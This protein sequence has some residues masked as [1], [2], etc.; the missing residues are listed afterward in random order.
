MLQRV[1]WCNACFGMLDKDRVVVGR[2]AE[3]AIGVGEELGAAVCRSAWLAGV[4]ALTV[5]IAGAAPASALAVEPASQVGGWVTDEPAQ[6]IATGGGRTYLGGGFSYIGP[7][8]GQGVVV[9]AATG[10]LVDG[11]AQLTG[12][13]ATKAI[14]D[15]TGGLYVAGYFTAA[16]DVQRPGLLHLLSDGTVDPSFAPDVN[17]SVTAIALAGTTLYLAGGFTALGGQS[18]PGLGAIDLA[19]GQVTSW[20]PP[21]CFST[22]YDYVHDIEV[23]AGIV[24]VAGEKSCNYRHTLLAFDAITG[25]VRDFIPAPDG[26]VLDV[27][28]TATTVY[29]AGSFHRIG[30]ADRAGLAAL[31]PSWGQATEWDP[32]PNSDVSAL[33]LTGD[34]LY[35]GGTFNTIGGSSRSGVARLST[36]TGQADA[37]APNAKFVRDIDVSGSTVYIGGTFGAVAGQ[38]R[39]LVAAVSATTG[40]PTAWAPMPSSEVTVV[41]AFGANVFIS[42]QFASVGGVQREGVAAIDDATDS[43]LPWDPHLTA[44]ASAPEAGGRVTVSDMLLD[45]QT[46]Y[47]A[48]EFSTADGASH[49]NLVAVDATDGHPRAWNPAPN[50]P[51]RALRRD[52]ATLYVGGAFTTVG[53]QPR[54][55]L[56]AIDTASGAPTPWNPGADAAVEALALAGD[57][58]YAAGAFQ[59]AGGAGRPG[60]AALSLATGAATAWNPKPVGGI[61]DLEVIGGAVYAAGTFTAIAGDGPPQLAKLDPATGAAMEWDAGIVGSVNDVTALGPSVLVVGDFTLAGG[62]PRNNVAAFDADDATVLP[63]APEADIGGRA[64]TV[65]DSELIVAGRFGDPNRFPYVYGFARIP[66]ARPPGTPKASVSMTRGDFTVTWSPSPDAD[67]YV[68]EQRD[69]AGGWAPVPGDPATPGRSFSGDEASEGELRFRVTAVSTDGRQS[70]PSATSAPVIVDRT[71]PAA[72]SIDTDRDAD[73]ESGWF[74]GPVHVSVKAEDAV[75]PDGSAGAGLDPAS[76]PAEQVF[77]TTGVHTLSATVRDRVGNTSPAATSVVRLDL[78]PPKIAIACPASV[79][80]GGTEA[81][82]WSASDVGSGLNGPAEGSILS[83]PL[84]QGAFTVTAPE[85]EDVAGLAAVPA[86]CTYTAIAIAPATGVGR[87]PERPPFTVA[88]AFRLPSQARCLKPGAQ[89]TL[90]Y[91]RPATVTVERVEVRVGRRRVLLRRGAKARKSITL[92]K[93][94]SKKFTLTVKVTIQDGTVATAKRTYSICGRSRR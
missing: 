17:G 57:T 10:A 45:G 23:A 43:V 46:L 2:R 77:A 60:A 32:R 61:L 6:V 64:V 22:P 49:P 76:L 62:E 15:G 40:T 38:S 90:T 16:D 65:S 59:A 27:E 73:S 78:D 53:G 84:Q 80:V 39:R 93:L 44:E 42:G 58:I 20:N 88:A 81:A 36:T 94:P 72:P 21:G 41:A 25:A 68:L 79:P 91:R 87:P 82:R 75:A 19:T 66:L 50:G 1:P 35:V 28:A 70:V 52:R 4:L 8:T 13:A 83:T 86:R 47:L 5:L 3:W 9:G 24:Y 30:G 56:A 55:H 37:W 31:D 92:T 14:P 11:S 34:A 48:G 67:H 71:P 54:A 33:E 69:A 7:R 12:G 26:T 29:A 74:T 18:R 63:W 85:V 51:V 89:L